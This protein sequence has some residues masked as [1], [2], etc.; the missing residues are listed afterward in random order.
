MRSGAFAE[1]ADALVD[2]AEEL[3]E[4][5]P[6]QGSRAWRLAATARRFAGEVASAL[7]HAERA[8][9]LAPPASLFSAEAYSELGDC[10]REV[11]RL[12]DAV[13]SYELALADA[14]GPGRIV[15]EGKRALALALSGQLDLAADVLQSLAGELDVEALQRGLS[16]IPSDEARDMAN[17]I[18]ALTELRPDTP[19]DDADRADQALLRSARA[20]LGDDLDLAYEA[21]LE[22][23][24]AARLAGDPIRY[25]GTCLAQAELAE[26]RDDRPLAYEAVAVGWAT[27]AQ[28]AGEETARAAFEDA[29]QGFIG[30]WGRSEYMAIRTAFDERQQARQARGDARPSWEAADG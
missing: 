30:R 10:Q 22:A 6:A 13:T 20:V 17:V 1:A 24:G 3:A 23:R 28:V 5:T 8:V 18:A 4:R 7:G 27:L 16:S 19:V 29:M 26:R 12:P 9:E 21:V 14:A 15:L 25:A 2:V 11:G